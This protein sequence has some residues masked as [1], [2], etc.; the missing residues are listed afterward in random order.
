MQPLDHAAI[1]LGEF[2][3]AA[4][5]RPG[6]ADRVGHLPLVE[7]Q[8]QPAGDR[9][10]ERP[11][12]ARR[13]KAARLVGVA[14]G[15]ADADHH[16]V[17]GD[18]RGDQRLAADPFAA[19]TSCATAKRRRQHRRAGMR[20]GAG[21]GQAVELEGMRQRPVGQ[22]RR[23]RLHRGAAAE[24]AA[25][26]ARPGALGIVDDDAAPGHVAAADAGRHRV[27][28]DVL[29]LGDDRRRQMLIPQPRGISGE[30][31]GF[32]GHRCLPRIVA[33]ILGR[34]AAIVMPAKAGLRGN[35]RALANVV[36]RPA[37]GQRICSD[38]G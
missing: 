19:P 1:A 28:D 27:G 21:P 7:P 31:H 36:V 35:R 9:R 20:A 23:R 5:Q 3:Q 30:L 10:A 18:H 25:G 17:A 33:A 14:G 8:Q 15:A 6:D 38:E 32:V 4:G 11:G 2:E 34:L 37:S 26:P 13:V 24:D 29:G 12:G 16:L 22:R